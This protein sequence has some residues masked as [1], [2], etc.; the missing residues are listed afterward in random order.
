[1]DE[2]STGGGFTGGGG[3]GRKHQ[4]GAG[5]LNLLGIGSQSES[6]IIK[7][8]N[9][10]QMKNL[11][12]DIR[13]YVDDLES[14]NNVS[15][16]VQDNKPE[17][18][19]HFDMD[20]MGRNNFTLVNLSAALSTFGREYSSG[21][22]FRQ[23]TESYDIMIKYAGEDTINNPDQEKTIDDLKHLEVSSAS[24]AVM[25][26]EEL[27]DVIFSYGMGNIHRENQEKRVTVTYS[28]KEKYKFIKGSA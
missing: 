25:E 8:Q 28:F 12:D 19:L 13:S 6:V 5:F 11:A 23:G 16:N 1:M 14:I 21:A 7:G 4:S 24:G 17:V 10:E 18:Q 9:F 20:Y 27:A 2:I 22:T 15:I 3:G 26:M